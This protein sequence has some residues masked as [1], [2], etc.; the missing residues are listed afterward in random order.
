ML[1]IG[2]VLVLVIQLLVYPEAM[3]TYSRFLAIH[4]ITMVLFMFAG[5]IYAA[6]PGDVYKLLSIF[7][8]F[9]AWASFLVF[10]LRLAGVPESVPFCI[11]YWPARLFLLFGFC[12]YLAHYIAVTKHS[13]RSL[14]G[15]A[16]C[17]LEVIVM[18]HKPILLAT[19]FSIITI[20][21]AFLIYLKG[22]RLTKILQ[23]VFKLT[24]IISIALG[25]IHFLFRTASVQRFM[26]FIMN[27]CCI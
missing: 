3:A 21:W 27:G 20:V 11:A 26:I 18:L 24:I 15:L 13:Q 5:F 19:L 22:Q 23:T 10:S 9:A 6:R 16:A 25:V 8:K 4:S 1:T 2:I 17:S 14:I 7:A 12:W